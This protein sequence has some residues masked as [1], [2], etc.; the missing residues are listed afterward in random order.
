MKTQIVDVLKISIESVEWKD[1]LQSFLENND[2]LKKWLVYEA[3]SGLYKFTGKA[4]KGSKYT[5]GETA[6]A[7]TML[8]FNSGGV[9]KKED[10]FPWSMAN[11]NLASNVKVDFKGSGRDRYIKLGIAAGYE[12]KGH[13]LFE[14]TITQIFEEEYETF[15][16]Q[17]LTEGFFSDI[18][19]TVVK[20][21]QAAAEFLWENIIKKVLK[22][23]KE[24]AAKGITVL[25][26][27]LGYEIEGDVS[28]ATPSW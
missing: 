1:K 15:Q 13:P 19:D 22:K 6:V 25:L 28:M 21:V 24:W 7:N 11:A 23:M 14:E 20:K 8:V 4:S 16:S 18:K 27:I 12:P 17:L 5:G 10:V 3:A 26:D 2:S 9:K